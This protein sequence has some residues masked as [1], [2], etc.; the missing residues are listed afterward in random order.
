LG[1]YRGALDAFEEVQVGLR[2]ELAQREPAAHTPDLATSLNNRVITL[3]QLG[4]HDEELELRTEVVVR[5]RVLAR[6]DPDQHQDTYQRE[7]DRL[8]GHFAKHDREP[9][10]GLASRGGSRPPIRA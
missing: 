1:R 2:R 6:L 3:C 4:R 5:W 10:A 7:R 9:D 8:A